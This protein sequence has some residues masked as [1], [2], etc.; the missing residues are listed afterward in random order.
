MVF[1]VTEWFSLRSGG[2]WILVLRGKQNV[3]LT[4][5]DFKRG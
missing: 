1:L 4:S 3:F 5:D 2:Y